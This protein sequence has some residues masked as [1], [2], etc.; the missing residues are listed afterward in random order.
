MKLEWKFSV[1]NK[2]AGFQSV[3]TCLCILEN[4]TL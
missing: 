2:D 3:L 1:Y 4:D